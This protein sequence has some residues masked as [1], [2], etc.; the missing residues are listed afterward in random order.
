[1]QPI[2]VIKQIIGTVMLAVNNMPETMP[3][4][5]QHTISI[6]HHVDVETIMLL[7]PF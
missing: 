2:A 3:V 1:M 4:P 6:R 7:H 5:M